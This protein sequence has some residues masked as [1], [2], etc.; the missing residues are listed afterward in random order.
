MLASHLGGPGS[1]PD[2]VMWDLLD[3][4]VFVQVFSEYFGFP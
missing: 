2:Q 1:I 4:V 3:K